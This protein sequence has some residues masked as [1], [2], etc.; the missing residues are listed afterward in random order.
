MGGVG[1]GTALSYLLYEVYPVLL[2][3]I[4]LL[5]T[6]KRYSVMLHRLFIA[7][8]FA[9]MANITLSMTFY[10]LSILR[11]RF[12]ILIPDPS[13]ES[14]TLLGVDGLILMMGVGLFVVVMGYLNVRKKTK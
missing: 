9:V 11:A 7:G 14:S 12:D 4:A 1:I 8:L 5:Y 10:V 6:W 3:G 13:A 2:F